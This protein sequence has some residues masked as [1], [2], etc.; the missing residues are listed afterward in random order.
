[1]STQNNQPSGEGR[2]ESRGEGQGNR[3]RG[4]RGGRNRRGRGG[5]SNR[6]DQNPGAE[7]RQEARGDDR[8]ERRADRSDRGQQRPQRQNTRQGSGSNGGNGGGNNR[9]GQQRSGGSRNNQQKQ[10]QGRKRTITAQEQVPD[11]NDWRFD[12][13]GYTV[14][15]AQSQVQQAASADRRIRTYIVD[16][17]VDEHAVDS[18]A[19][20]VIEPLFQLDSHAPS[21]DRG[22]KMLADLFAREAGR[23]N[24]PPADKYKAEVP[25][26]ESRY[27]PVSEN[28]LASAME[29]EMDHPQEDI[30]LLNEGRK[31][32]AIS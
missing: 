7:G 5:Q 18:K 17:H 32:A 13:R 25:E 28:A 10:Q 19:W 31:G 1:M 8:Q 21:F 6:G 16:I 15:L 26:P 24:L 29:L 11:L 23:V 30:D 27:A 2:S 3:S 9:G 14:W 4:Q 20:P 22:R 12:H